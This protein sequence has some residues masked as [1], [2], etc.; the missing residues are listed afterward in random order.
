MTPYV[1]PGVYKISDADARKFL[2]AQRLADFEAKTKAHAEV[3]P[4]ARLRHLMLDSR[5]T[6]QR[7]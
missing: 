3:T 5:L 4:A 2:A 1:K 7:P 6:E